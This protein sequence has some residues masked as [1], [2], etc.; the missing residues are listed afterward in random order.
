MVKRDYYEILNLPRTASE[1]EIK[2]SYR[3]LAMQFHPDRNPGDKEAELRFK[4]AAEAYEVLRD[5]QKRSIYD[6]YGHE[7]LQ[8]TGFREFRGFDDIFASFGDVFE[9]FFGFGTSKRTRSGP[10]PG[11][12]LRYDLSIAFV[13]AAFGKETEIEV[14]KLEA[15]AACGSTGCKPGTQPS[16]C[17]TCRGRG[18]IVRAEGFFRISTTCPHCRGAG[19]VIPDPCGSCA[20]SG[21][22][23]VRRKVSIKIPPG[24][25]TGSRLRLRGEGEGGEKSGP[26]GDLYVVLHVEPHEF[27]ERRGQDV[28]CTLPLSFTQAALGDELEVPTLKGTKRVNTPPG[29]Q[30][31]EA[32]RLKGEGFPSLRGQQKGDQVVEF[33]VK[34]PVSLTSRQEE[35]LREFAELESQKQGGFFK[36]LFR[37]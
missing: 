26:P 29:L 35:L 10:Q 4:E 1:D 7:G 9:D 20:G 14:S 15:C 23:R 2:R 25:D 8:G 27:F 37:K 5:P 22:T 11:A 34:T 6:N 32:I 30:S 19:S 33:T 28:H 3:R 13:D 18:Q 36:K 21:R 12:D 24:V 16:T 17:P 31:G